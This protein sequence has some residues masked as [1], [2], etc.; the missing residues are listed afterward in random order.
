MLMNNY[1][2]TMLARL[3]AAQ[4]VANLVKSKRSEKAINSQANKERAFHA[5][6]LVRS[7]CIL[8]KSTFCD[9]VFAVF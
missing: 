5:Y 6:V 4:G 2:K 8:S 3:L 7:L 9:N 1:K